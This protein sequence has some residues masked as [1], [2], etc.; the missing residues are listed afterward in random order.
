M[1]TQKSGGGKGTDSAPL[2]S[3]QT[4]NSLKTNQP[5]PDMLG[6]YAKATPSMNQPSGG[7]MDAAPFAP[8]TDNDGE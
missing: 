7:S 2:P 4:L 8:D 5:F 6:N 1:T 3:R